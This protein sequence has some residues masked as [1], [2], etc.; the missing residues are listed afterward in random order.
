MQDTSFLTNKKI[1]K[2][3]KTQP[4]TYEI[5]SEFITTT[6]SQNKYNINEPQLNKK[7]QEHYIE[8]KQALTEAINFTLNEQSNLENLQDTFN[9]IT[10][11]L[12]I[13]L[14][15]E[16][17]KKIFYLIYIEFIG[18]WRLEPLIQDPLVKK[19]FIK[20]PIIIQH[21]IY[22]NIYTNI[23]LTE[24]DKQ[25]IQRKIKLLKNPLITQTEITKITKNPLTLLKNNNASPEMLAFLWL[26][27][28]NKKPIIFTENFLYLANIFLPPNSN[29]LT[30]EFNY[31]NSNT[32]Y[33]TQQ[34]DEQYA[35]LNNK[36]YKGPA[37]KI[38]TTKD[39]DEMNYFV[40]Y[41]INN[42][43]YKIKEKGKEIF[44]KQQEKFYHAHKQSIFLNTQ[45]LLQELN[46]RTKL[47]IVL[48]QNNLSIEDFR[49]VINIYYKD[50]TAV[51][52]KAGLL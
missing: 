9:T 11:E 2:L 5:F 15:E 36:E 44:V 21:Q 37:T 19:I 12:H 50:K 7:E 46:L 42:T 13:K 6:I 34:Q 39:I 38:L 45:N 22:K 1:P 51:L 3:Q 52:K 43:I 25:I 35:L 24:Q 30:N 18:L 26:L 48:L 27:I 31:I 32:Q 49:Q 20:S 16:E 23:Q 41:I 29:I 10:K 33:S 40:F 17:Y 28:E 47:I 8:I 14:N 4:I